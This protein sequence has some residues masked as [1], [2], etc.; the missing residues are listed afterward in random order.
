MEGLRVVLDATRD[1][2]PGMPPPVNDRAGGTV[3][4]VGGIPN[5]TMSGKPA[6]AVVVTLPDGS[7]VM[8]QTTLALL[9]GAT[10]AL[11]ARYGEPE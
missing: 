2:L 5:G 3:T 4:A 6:V 10:K 1:D 8:G 7:T 11:T 9:A